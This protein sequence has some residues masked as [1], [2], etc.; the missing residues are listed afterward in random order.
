MISYVICNW[1]YCD[2][3]I[4]PQTCSLQKYIT[5]VCHNWS[6]DVTCHNWSSLVIVVFNASRRLHTDCTHCISSHHPCCLCRNAV[7]G[8]V[9]NSHLWT[10]TW[11]ILA[12]KL[13]SYAT[14]DEDLQGNFQVSQIW[15]EIWRELL[16]PFQLFRWVLLSP[17]NYLRSLLPAFDKNRGFGRLA[18]S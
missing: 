6:R 4:G 10:M 8:W 3:K 12:S 1:V 9:H 14:N 13:R 17:S 18:R 7:S 11:P 2:Q 16:R 15:R 5:L